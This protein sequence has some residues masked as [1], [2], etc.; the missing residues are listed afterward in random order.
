MLATYVPKQKIKYFRRAILK[1]G[2]HNF[3]DF[4]WRYTSNMWHALVAELMLQ[5]TKAEQ[6]LPVYL[7]FC[8]NYPLP[9][10]YL[11]T[12]SSP[13]ESLGL[14]WRENNLNRL[15]SILSNQQIPFDKVKLLELPGIGDY[16]A[17]AF[18]SLHSGIRSPIIDS[19]VVRLYGRFL[20]FPTNSETRRKGWFIQLSE[21]ITPRRVFKDFNYGV[22]DF[23]RIV[24]R[25]RPLCSECVLAEKCAY[26]REL[27]GLFVS[28]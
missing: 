2:R 4:P 15:A 3:S 23:T 16:I 13:F 22:I 12:N 20:G 9:Q 14:R 26:Y 27:N 6:V 19:N 25:P 18:L 11:S 5:R 21:D 10:D 8:K 17:S 7:Q 24:C 1:W 28:S